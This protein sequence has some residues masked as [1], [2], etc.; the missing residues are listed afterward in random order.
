MK[1]PN[2]FQQGDVCVE[3]VSSLP[4]GAVKLDSNIVREGEKTGHM[5]RLV[6]D[7]QIFIHDGVKYFVVGD[8]GATLMHDEHQ[9]HTYAPGIHKVL[10]GVFEY[11]YETEEAKRVVD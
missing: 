4:N 3:R 5:H 7:G 1:N 6:G 9:V 2:Q 8:D 10:P 11:D